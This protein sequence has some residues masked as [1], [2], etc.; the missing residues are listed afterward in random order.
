MPAAVRPTMDTIDF[1][2][3]CRLVSDLVRDL[4]DDRLADPTPCEGLTVGDLCH[5][6]VGLTLAFSMAAR[7]EKPPGGGQP[8]ADGSQ[9]ETG[10]RDQVV[11]QLDDMASG[12]AE[13]AAYEGMTYAGP[14]ELPGFV[15]AQ[16]ALNEVVVHGWD[17]AV[18]TGRPYDAD[19]AAVAVCLEF[20]TSF[21]APDDAP[22]DD[23]KLFDPP[24][25][26]PDD[27]PVLHRLLGATGRDPRWTP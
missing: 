10:W 9:L 20:A 16:V 19:P 7:K 17:V 22:D 18:A 21:E 1:G 8:T 6:L 25:P 3:S 15:A 11:A 2:P 14:I 12:W 24:V 4:P 5:H 13:P 26:V 23:A 27:A